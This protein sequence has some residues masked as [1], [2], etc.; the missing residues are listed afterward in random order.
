MPLQMLFFITYIGFSIIV[1]SL[2]NTF[3]LHFLQ[4]KGPLCS[5]PKY[6]SSFLMGYSATAAD[7]T[8]EVAV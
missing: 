8:A 6:V 7:V 1:F 3:C 5:V 4:T 2:L